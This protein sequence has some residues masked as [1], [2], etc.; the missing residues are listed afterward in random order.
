M[1]WDFERNVEVGGYQLKEKKFETEGVGNHIVK[2]LNNKMNYMI[3]KNYILDMETNLP[4]KQ[5]N[6]D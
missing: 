5:K 2:G 4:I 6:V 1:T 3:N